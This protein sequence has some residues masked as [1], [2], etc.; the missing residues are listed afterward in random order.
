MAEGNE[1]EIKGSVDPITI[2]KSKIILNQMENCVCKIHVGK[3]KGTGFFIKIPYKNDLLNVLISNNHVLN[4]EKIALGQNVTISLNNGETI[5]N[6]EI[7]E[8][9]K[10]YTNENLDITIIE[11]KETDP[12]K[13]FLN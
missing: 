2:E 8:K 10:I 13:N 12:I 6:I 4:D 7:D 1:I 9:R 5:I 3:K 11:L